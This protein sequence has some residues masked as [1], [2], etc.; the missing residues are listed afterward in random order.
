MFYNVLLTVLLSLGLIGSANAQ[1]YWLNI[2]IADQSM[3]L[4]VSS[5]EKC[6]EAII[7]YVQQQQHGSISCDV[8]PL[9]ASVNT[10]Q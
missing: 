8:M 3:S 1:T 5:N 10:G 7:R 9:P 2:V 4:P 6:S